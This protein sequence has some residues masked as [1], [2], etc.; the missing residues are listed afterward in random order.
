M[1]TPRT[2]GPHAGPAQ[3]WL[4][5]HC[6]DLG[7]G[8][9]ALRSLAPWIDGRAAHLAEVLRGGGR[10]LAAG[11]GGS[12][13]EAQHLTAELVGR[14][15]DERAPLSAISLHAETSS[16]TAIVNDYGVDEMFARQVAA[17]GRPGDVLMLLSTS[18][19][20]ANVVSAARRAKTL[21]IAVWALTGP[22]PSTLGAVSDEVLRC[23]GDSTA[24]IQEMHLVAVHALCAAVD[25]H[26]APAGASTRLR[27]SAPRATARRRSTAHGHP[28]DSP[29]VTVV[30]D[31]VLDRDVDG[32]VT[33]FSPDGPVPVVDT[34]DV[35][36]SPGGAGLTAILC[37][38]EV[39]TRL[40]APIGTDGAALDLVRLLDKHVELFALPQEGATRRKTRVRSVG[41]TLVRVDD[42]GPARP[43]PVDAR[44]VLRAFDG[45]DVVL[46]S[47]YGAGV[48]YDGPVRGAVLDAVG[49]V[50]V[51]WDPHP[52]GGPPVAG[53][54]LVTPNLAEALTAASALELEI[55]SD[56]VGGLCQA[57]CHAWDVDTVCVTVGERGAFLAGRDG[58]PLY[59][60]ARSVTGDACGAGDRFAATAAV[61]LARGAAVREAVLRAVGAASGWVEAGGADGFRRRDTTRDR[62]ADVGRGSGPGATSLAHLAARLHAEGTLV[63]T[64]GCFD[65]LHA[66]HVATLEAASRLGDQLVVLLNSDESVRR[67]KGPRRPV[68]PQGDRARLLDALDCVAHVLVFDDDDPAAVLDELRPDVWA[69]GGDYVEDDLKESHVVR[70]HGGR[71]V[72]LPYLEGRSTTAILERSGAPTITPHP[73]KETSP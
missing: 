55:D 17:H 67:L 51:V 21:G 14:F 12:A 62:T 9:A 48:T 49:K 66:G 60:S 1:T 41:R 40:V 28:E 18:G 31:V 27:T 52:R 63:A 33:R 68:V 22:G 35:R 7:R 2:H 8:L 26:L 32:Q 56:D 58:D 13:A 69:K 30:G 34:V 10:L 46:V 65:V 6:A 24:A 45:S 39:P 5:E 16:L 53:A 3:R 36:Q 4:G 15:R 50:P 54:T 37:A 44:D 19:E 57:L 47:D 72:I 70:R 29:V 43:G 61:A 11:N 59:I 25:E 64:G 38:Q 23:P 20:S 73:S 71:V 42:G